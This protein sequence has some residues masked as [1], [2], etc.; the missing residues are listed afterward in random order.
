MVKSN[1][2]PRRNS[3]TKRSSPVKRTATKKPASGSSSSHSGVTGSREERV[4]GALAQLRALGIDTPSRKL[5]MVMAGYSNLDSFNVMMSNESK[6]KTIELLDGQTMK[7]TLDGIAKS[8]KVNPPASNKELQTMVRTTMKVPGGVPTKVFDYLGDG[9]I[10]TKAEL[11]MH[12][13]YEDEKNA[14]FG[15]ALSRVTA[16]GVV[17][18]TGDHYRLSDMCFLPGH[19]AT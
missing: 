17:E 6:K 3:I 4:L 12:C 13:G 8:P 2:P 15:V 1:K 11:A 9:K 7:A 10:R 5:V 18:K 16:N 14:S 19:R